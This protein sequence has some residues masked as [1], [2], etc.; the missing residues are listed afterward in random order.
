MPAVFS[1]L[2]FA[3]AAAILS[4]AIAD[5][6]VESVSNSGIFGGRYADDNHLGVL[7]AL[8]AGIALTVALLAVSCARLWRGSARGSGDWLLVAAKTISGRSPLRDLPYA[9]ALQMVALYAIERFEALLAGGTVE[10]LEWL[11][12]PIAFCLVA[13]ALIGASCTLLL[14]ALV[15]ALLRT[16]ASFAYGAVHLVW[17]A[18]SRAVAPSFRVV[19]GTSFCRR[20]QAP[21]S[22]QTGGRA[23][24]LLPSAA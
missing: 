6:F 12:G 1:R 7:P 14:A 9:F 15:R 21:H 2:S 19:A 5:P 22:R 24:P 20:A 11:G 10:G 18:P 16:F 8:L 17:L 23:P 4:A 13:H 3:L